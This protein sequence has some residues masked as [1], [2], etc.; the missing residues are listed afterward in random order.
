[1]LK[2]EIIEKITKYFKLTHFEA[3][4][5]YDDI[6]QSIMKGVKE[7]NIADV[8]NLGEFIVKY[9]ENNHSD[10]KKTVEFLPSSNLEEAVNESSGYVPEFPVPEDVKKPEK[11]IPP[12]P[13]IE[14]K[15]ENQDEVKPVENLSKVPD[16]KPEKSTGSSLSV[17]D[18][19][20]RKREEIINKLTPQ[21]QEEYHHLLHVEEGIPLNV[22]KPVVIPESKKDKEIVSNEEITETK[23][24]ESNVKEFH[25]QVKDEKEKE[26]E[27][28]EK[29]TSQSFSDYFT[30]VKETGSIGGSTKPVPE[31]VIPPIAV[32]L[33]KEITGG[34]KPPPP[35]PVQQQ[36]TE[37]TEEKIPP[38]IPRSGNG[39]TKDSDVVKKDDSYYIW[40]KDS[41][42]NAIDTQTMSY[43]YELLYQATKEAEYKSKLRI[44][45]TT[46]ILFFSIV[47]LLLIFSPVIY[48]Y[49][50]T[51]KDDQSN[52]EYMPEEQGSTEPGSEVTS[53]TPPVQNTAPVQETNIT[54]P[55]ENPQKTAQQQPVEQN[56]TQPQSEQKTSPPPVTEVKKEPPA[57]QNTAP[58]ISGIIKTGLGWIDE[59]NKVIYVQLES[60]KFTV[61]ESAWDSEEKANKRINAVAAYNI[62]GMTGIVFRADLGAKG[63][64][65]RA[66]FGEFTTIEEAV[67]K[68]GELRNKEKMKLHAFLFSILMLT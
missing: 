11:M 3:E 57:T 37:K 8:S 22:P 25:E 34:E 62:P 30:E 59:K 49:F 63:V 5:I 61:Q 45:V 35:P 17:E 9:N 50:F 4:K 6:F 24:T 7:D 58:K 20:K 42:P 32:D 65:F 19:L 14:S 27:E 66:R 56:S 21:H 1:M 60:G 44:Y 48:K 23:D 36:E 2:Q 68:A 47:L 12:A 64:W 43:E 52:E 40:Y 46:F 54:Q 15:K 51:P 13:V 67:Q 16:L 55:S 33:H 29:I 18:E 28:V 26:S 41:E 38:V 31:T 10:Y 53:V 39:Y